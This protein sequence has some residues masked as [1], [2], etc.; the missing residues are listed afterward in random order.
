MTSQNLSPQQRKILEEY[1]KRKERLER[2]DFD[3]LLF[4]G[5]QR[6]FVLDPSPRK[7]AVCSRRAGKT[8]GIVVYALKVMHEHS[9]CQIPYI[10]LTRAQGKRNIWLTLQKLDKSLKLG[11]TFNN[12]E[13]TYTIPNGSQ[14]FISGANDETEIQRLRGNKYPLAIIDEAQSF[15]PLI[16]SLVREIIE[17]AVG[18]Y[19]GTIAITGT[20]GPACAGFYYEI[21]NGL[22]SYED[23][24]KT[25]YP[26]SVHHWTLLEN[27]FH[28]FTEEDVENTRKM[29]GWLPD[30]PSFLREYK[31][32][33]VKDDSLKVY[34]LSDRNLMYT[35]PE[36]DL[37]YALGIDL[38]YED[39]TA[40][41]VLGYNESIGQCFV[42]ESFK[43]EHLIPSAVAVQVQKLMERFDFAHIVADAGGFGKGYVEEM[44][45][46]YSIPVKPAEKTQKY[47]FIELL[48]GDLQSGSL[49][50]LKNRNQELVDE[51][52]T[53]QFVENEDGTPDRTK[54]DERFDDHLCDALLYGW[55]ACRQFFYDPEMLGPKKDSKEWW[56]EREREMEEYEE[57]R[58]A[59]QDD[60]FAESGGAFDALDESLDSES[61]DQ[62]ISDIWQREW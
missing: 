11:G 53:L 21:S 18:D 32:I 52:G 5:P 23:N 55:R 31:G 12:N 13:L 59:R 44:S 56:S 25:I 43:K 40:F 29:N 24:G 50:I 48:N 60:P 39:S 26:W 8:H 16:R 45:Q 20:P 22:V 6:D 2:V 14:L 19:R 3:K 42:L 61:P 4:E 9:Y 34:K 62:W 58:L 17:P 7:A 30:N 47:G 1:A 33:W 54:I 35:R 37:T 27:P 57:R 41:V 51:L 28:P 15:R 49:K 36:V 10:T 46:R 38:G